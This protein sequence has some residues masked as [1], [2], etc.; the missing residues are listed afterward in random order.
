MSNNIFSAVSQYI[1]KFHVENLRVKADIFL[2]SA[3]FGIA[4]HFWNISL[5]K[6]RSFL[7]RKVYVFKHYQNETGKL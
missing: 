4:P 6:G 7:F 2:A 5:L 3:L 1:D